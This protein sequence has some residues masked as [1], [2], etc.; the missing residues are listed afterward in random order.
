MR[1]Q[2]VKL[3]LRRPFG[4]APEAEPVVY[5]CCTAVQDRLWHAVV[6]SLRR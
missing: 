2:S 3:A 4:I 1:T 5:E 6:V